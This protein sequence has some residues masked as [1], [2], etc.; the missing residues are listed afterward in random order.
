MNKLKKGEFLTVTT[1]PHS[2]YPNKFYGVY[3]GSGSRPYFGGILKNGQPD[4]NQFAWF[5][6]W[7]KTKKEAY[8]LAKRLAPN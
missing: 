7:C 3:K 8:E 5:G 6:S 4:G 2:A 1:T